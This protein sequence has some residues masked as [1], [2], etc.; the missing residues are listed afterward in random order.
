MVLCVL[1]S[2]LLQSWICH[3]PVNHSL[4]PIMNGDIWDFRNKKRWPKIMTLLICDHKHKHL[5]RA[6]QPE[7]YLQTIIP[8]D[9]LLCF[10]NSQWVAVCS[11][12]SQFQEISGNCGESEYFLYSTVVMLPS[13]FSTCSL[14]LFI[15]VSVTQQFL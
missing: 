6:K 3:L 4:I 9:G 13:C 12:L 7:S 11:E 2:V 5:Q 10:P 14:A 8:Q 15:P 1:L